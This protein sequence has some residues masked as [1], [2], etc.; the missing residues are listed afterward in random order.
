MALFRCAFIIDLVQNGSSE[1][2]Y[3][4]QPTE[5]VQ[6]VNSLMHNLCVKRAAMLGRGCQLKAIRI[7]MVR[8]NLGAAVKKR[9]LSFRKALPGH[10]TIPSCP[11]QISLLV[12]CTATNSDSPRNWMFSGVYN[13]IFPDDDGLNMGVNGFATLFNT[14]WAQCQTSHVGWLARTLNVERKITAY[15]V[16]PV[17]GHVEYTVQAP[18]MGF[19]DGDKPQRVS[20]EFTSGPTPFDGP[21]VVIPSLQTVMV[22]AKPRPGAANLEGGLMRTYN[23]GFADLGLADPQGNLGLMLPVR[24]MRRGRGAF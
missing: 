23:Y 11:S 9:G 10:A 20:V 15:D 12:R 3:T 24:P 22:S 8:N 17:T 5:S 13:G 16:D 1:T 19:V 14:F 2:F 6:A 7:T 18:G 21:Q 4:E